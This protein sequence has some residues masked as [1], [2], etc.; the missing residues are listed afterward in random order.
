MRFDWTSTGGRRRMAVLACALSG[1]AALC[2]P[3]ALHL[4]VRIVYNPSASVP[5]GWYLIEPVGT[6]Q[7]G[8]VV[9]ARLPAAA[10]ALAARR[11]YLP[12]GVPLIKRIGAMAPQH[13]CAN[14]ATVCIDGA[15]VALTLSVD[16][17]ER[18]MPAW[19]HCGPLAEGE[20]LLLGHTDSASFDSRYFGPVPAT[21]VLGRAQPLW[22]WD[23]PQ[24]WR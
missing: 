4:P 7:V 9:L 11:G 19:R 16:G 14:G 18:P 22:T 3:L 12:L 15:L 17:R 21:A 23:A 24:A 1:A 13:V 10:A 2:A 8:D 5:R 20:L 6:L